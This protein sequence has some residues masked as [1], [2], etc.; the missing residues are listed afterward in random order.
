MCRTLLCFLVFHP[1]L[2]NNVVYALYSVWLNG[3][4]IKKKTETE[5]EVQQCL[6]NIDNKRTLPSPYYYFINVFLLPFFVVVVSSRESM[7][8]PLLVE[9][10]SE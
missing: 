4:E 8:Q 10:C 7:C 9:C 6:G 2:L 3:R 1:P 5:T